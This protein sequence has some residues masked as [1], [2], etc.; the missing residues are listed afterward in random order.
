MGIYS[1]TSRIGLAESLDGT[2]FPDE[3]RRTRPVPS[4]PHPFTRSRLR[5]GRCAPG[6]NAASQGGGVQQLRAANPSGAGGRS[7][8]CMLQMV[9]VPA[10]GALREGISERREKEA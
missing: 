6:Q 9:G 5:L 7:V 10:A 4:R 2:T 1:G 8:S 3:L